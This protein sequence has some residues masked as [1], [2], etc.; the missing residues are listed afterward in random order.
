V[1]WGHRV[2]RRAPRG[3]VGPWLRSAVLARRRVVLWGLGGVDLP[4]MMVEVGTPLPVSLSHPLFISLS[5]FLHSLPFVDGRSR[6]GDDAIW[7]PPHRGPP[8]RIEVFPAR[9]D[10]WSMDRGPPAWIEQPQRGSS[11]H[12]CR[13]RRWRQPTSLLLCALRAA[14]WG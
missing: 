13:I 5:L 14:Q 4:T 12:R 8:T 6:S 9:I 7:P 2:G 10:L 11:H 1:A 3:G